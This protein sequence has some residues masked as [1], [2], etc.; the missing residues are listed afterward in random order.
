MHNTLLKGLPN[1]VSAEPVVALW[2]LSRIIR[3]NAALR[4]LVANQSS[5]EILA[6]IEQSDRFIDFRA[7]LADYLET[8]GFRCS[9]ELM[10]RQQCFQEDPTGLIDILATYATLD[11]PSP[12]D[13]MREQNEERL[14]ETKRVMKA[15]RKTRMFRF[16]PLL[17]VATFARRALWWTHASIRFRERAR[18]KQALL[19]RRLRRIVLA[20]GNDLTRRRL[21]ADREDVFFL[22]WRELD[23]LASGNA[24]FSGRVDDQIA[25]RKREH[26]ELSAM[27]PPDR[28][29]LGFGDYYRGDSA[30]P[31]PAK[32][33]DDSG[34]MHGISACGGQVTARAAVLRDLSD[35]HLL[36]RGD[37]LVTSQTDPGWAPMFFLIKGLVMERGGMLSHGAIIAREFG[38]PSV[39]GV[40]NA[41]TRIAQGAQVSVDGSRGHVQIVD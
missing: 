31:D 5:E 24:M 26:E 12:L 39:V 32:P 35:A 1:V 4:E 30:A 15:L 37:V 40:R 27:T 10:L 14:R 20:L 34:E 25:A 8:W 7:A 9:G 6:A 22:T 17:S 41:T 29:M 21:I 33:D 16:L 2:Q 23:R 18:L 11:G 38:I 36:E 3:D 28:V 19:Y 13:V